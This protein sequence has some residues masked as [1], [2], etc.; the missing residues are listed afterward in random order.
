MNLLTPAEVL[1][2]TREL[3][4]NIRIDARDTRIRPAG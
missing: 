2:A 1:T 4:K 3:L